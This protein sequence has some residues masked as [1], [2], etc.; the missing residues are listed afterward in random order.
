MFLQAE[1]EDK[2]DSVGTSESADQLDQEQKDNGL[3][4]TPASDTVKEPK[5][6]IVEEPESTPD[7]NTEEATKIVSPGRVRRCKIPPI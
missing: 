6:S 1:M 4:L 5:S 7:H 2:G 3:E